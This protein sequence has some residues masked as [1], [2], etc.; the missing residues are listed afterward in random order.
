MNLL[1]LIVISLGLG[2][3]LGVLMIITFPQGIGKT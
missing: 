3:L 1:T 2:I